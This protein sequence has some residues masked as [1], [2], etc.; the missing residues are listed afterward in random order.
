MTLIRMVTEEVRQVAHG[1][2]LGASD[3]Q[4]QPSQLKS[5]SNNLSAAWQGGNAEYYGGEIFR[6]SANLDREIQNLLNLSSRVNNEVSEW[7]GADSNGSRLGT[8]Q[9]SHFLPASGALLS[10]IPTA[11]VA[12]NLTVVNMPPASPNTSLIQ[13]WET[14]LNLETSDRWTKKSGWKDGEA[15]IEVGAKLNLADGAFI[16]GDGTSNWD[17]GGRDIG[18][19]IGEYGI[20]QGEAGLEFGIGTDGFNAGAYGEY[21]LAAA[22]GSMVL[23]SSML[24]ITLSGGASAVSADGFIGIKS[25]DFVP[26]VGAFV[27][28]SFASGE[29][30][31]GMNIAGVNVGVE[32]G[33][34]A[35]IE[36]GIKLG[37]ETEVKAG[38]FKI[39]LN[40]G[41]AITD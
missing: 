2:S 11:L 20:S 34:A 38:P 41:K 26:T 4:D 9:I 15:D 1:L 33:L 8:I 17:L 3:L 16:E 12:R 18:G 32:A 36:F 21:D 35:G 30:G 13:S 5:L 14:G 23:G 27:G 10:T 40:F 37:G 25:E 24:G 19:A 6:L 39:G 29:V 31:L 7:E 28:G 22:S